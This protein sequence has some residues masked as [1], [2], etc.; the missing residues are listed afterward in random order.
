M[1]G[2][3]DQASAR[4]SLMLPGGIQALCCQSCTGRSLKTA[5]QGAQQTLAGG[6]WHQLEA[7]AGI[8]RSSSVVS[9]RTHW[10]CFTS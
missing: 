10:S 3:L 9:D 8:S 1:P 6:I 5:A 4:V 7:S 2:C